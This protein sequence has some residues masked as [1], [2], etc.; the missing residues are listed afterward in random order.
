VHLQLPRTVQ[1]ETDLVLIQ[2]NSMKVKTM[3]L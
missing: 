2:R 3:F 1:T